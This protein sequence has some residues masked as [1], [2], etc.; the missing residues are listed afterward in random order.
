[1]AW[2]SAKISPIGKKWENENSL[3]AGFIHM[4][5][6]AIRE[7]ALYVL[8]FEVTK[9]IFFYRVQKIIVKN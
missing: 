9:S 5:V 1:M 4:T 8:D 6:W 2:N 3:Q 7:K